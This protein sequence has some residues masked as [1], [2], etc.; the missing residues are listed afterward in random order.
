MDQTDYRIIQALQQNSRMTMK[1]LGAHVHLTG[2]A[3]AARVK[4]LEERGIIERY[5]IRINE[6]ELGHPIHAM[7]TIYTT[8]TFHDPYHLYL[9]EHRIY[10]RRH[11]K[12]SGDGCYVLECRFPS[13]EQLNQFLAG[14]SRHVNYKLSLIIADT[15]H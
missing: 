1:E 11:V 5:T 15:S 7:I 12:V 2:Q 8:S 9:D 14:L 4:K 6:S 3:T 10:V 13:N